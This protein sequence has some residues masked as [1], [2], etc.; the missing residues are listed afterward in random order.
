MKTQVQHFEAAHRKI[1]DLNAAFMELV[2]HPTNPMT[3][4]D[5]EALIA[6]RPEHYGR[7]AGFIDKLPSRFINLKIRFHHNQI[8]MT[9]EASNDDG[10]WRTIEL[11]RYSDFPTHTY[12][13]GG[14]KNVRCTHRQEQ[15]YL[16]TLDAKSIKYE[17]VRNADA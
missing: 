11:Q 5:I 10:P 1:A 3:R 2:N 9:I 7:F 8:G 16:A 4:E 12:G 6:R 13:W 14:P 17:V 15:A